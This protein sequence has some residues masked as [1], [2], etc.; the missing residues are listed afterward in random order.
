MLGLELAF[1]PTEN[2]IGKLPLPHRV[3]SLWV[4]VLIQ[5]GSVLTVKK[6][7][8]LANGGDVCDCPPGS[9]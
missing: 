7:D 4:T 3:N 5:F 1:Y 6:S 2:R 9:A 8:P